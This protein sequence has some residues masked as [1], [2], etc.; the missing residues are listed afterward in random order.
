MYL[1]LKQVCPK[2]KLLYTNNKSYLKRSDLWV[3]SLNF[4]NAH[5]GYSIPVGIS[6][7]ASERVDQFL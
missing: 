3:K 2:S 4:F 7:A 1:I 6:Q 5:I